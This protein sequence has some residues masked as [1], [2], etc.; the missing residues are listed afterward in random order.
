MIIKIYK[1]RVI[2]YPKLHKCLKNYI[3]II[4]K[5][6]I[7]CVSCVSHEHD[8]GIV[9]R[10]RLLNLKVL[11]DKGNSLKDDCEPLNVAYMDVA[12]VIGTANQ[13]YLRHKLEPTTLCS[14]GFFL[15]RVEGRG[16]MWS[17]LSC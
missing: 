5:S 10:F 14:L 1:N 15:N 6:I 13:R 9:A 7:A 12:K 4:H 3:K 8:I 11:Q 2:S 17:L 16:F